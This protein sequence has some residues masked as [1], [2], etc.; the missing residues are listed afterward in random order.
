MLGKFFDSRVNR[1]T[2][3]CVAMMAIVFAGLAAKAGNMASFTEHG[4]LAYYFSVTSRSLGYILAG[5]AYFAAGF[6]MVLVAVSL[7]KNFL[8]AARGKN[9]TPRMVGSKTFA[10][11]ARN[12]WKKIWPGVAIMAPAIIFISIMSF[13]LDSLNLIDKA[14]LI[15]IVLVNGEHALFGNYGF[16]IFAGAN[17][18]AWFA[19]FVILSFN[20]MSGILLTAAFI[21]AY[22]RLNVLR[23][24]AA[25]FCFGMLLMVPVWFAMPALSPQDRFITNIYHLPV[26]AVIASAV[27]DFHPVPPIANFLANIESGKDT[28]TDLPTST[29]PSAHAAW[30]VLTGYYLFLAQAT[31]PWYRRWLGWIALPFLIASTLGTVILA[32]HYFF[33]PIVGIIIA[34]VAIYAVNK[35]AKIDETPAAKT[36]PIDF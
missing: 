34:V 20:N 7:I 24:F 22:I 16:I 1:L 32:Q 29:F 10:G 19:K 26:P 33:D 18:P 6:L 27:A 36:L 11:A 8:D 15:D 5:A 28:L 13:A 9:I 35:L 12:A 31:A 21:I 2:Y 3:G 4:T 25:A 23:Q 17:Y 14:R 30:A